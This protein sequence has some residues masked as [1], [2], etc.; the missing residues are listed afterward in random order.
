MDKVDSNSRKSS[1]NSIENSCSPSGILYSYE[2]IF[3]DENSKNSLWNSLYSGYISAVIVIKE[4]PVK[5]RNLLR[6]LFWPKCDVCKKR[7]AYFEHF[8]EFSRCAICEAENI[9][10]WIYVCW[11]C[12][13]IHEGHGSVD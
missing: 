13:T 2:E 8:G 6:Y 12:S 11:E 1:K 7:P 10:G 9:N 5:W 4:I 3:K